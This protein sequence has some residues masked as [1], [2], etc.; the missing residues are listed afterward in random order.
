MRSAGT[1]ISGIGHVVL[2]GWLISGWGFSSE[3]LPFEV[4]EVSVVSSEEF[5]AMVAATTPGWASR[6]R[7][8]ARGPAWAA[9]RGPPAC[10][11]AAQDVS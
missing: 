8:E 7:A 5:A 2:I 3:P 4:A 11:V 10:G 9:A 6:G 1:Y